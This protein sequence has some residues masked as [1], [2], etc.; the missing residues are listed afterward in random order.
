MSLENLSDELREAVIKLPYR[1]GYFISAADRTGGAQAD[2]TELESLEHL[3]TFYAEDAV[4]GEFSQSV[5]A[6]TVRRKV[7]WP[8]WRTDIAKTPRDVRDV[9]TDLEIRVDEKNLRAF[10]YNLYELAQTVAESFSETQHQKTQSILMSWLHRAL[11]VRP[12]TQQN[13]SDIEQRALKDI[14]DALSIS[15]DV[16]HKRGKK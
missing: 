13:I 4:K 7:F 12:A 3:L 6:E 16:S 8:S 15:L 1:V 11:G 14:E 9:L 10:K 2:Q 5:M